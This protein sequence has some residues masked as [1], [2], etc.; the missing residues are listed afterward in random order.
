MKAIHYG[1]PG[2]K[3][4]GAALVPYCENGYAA[5]Q[6]NALVIMNTIPAMV[7]CKHCLAGMKRAA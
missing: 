4:D 7:D 3:Q 6:R 2:T 5:F 1:V